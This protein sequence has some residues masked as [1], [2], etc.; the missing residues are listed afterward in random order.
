MLCGHRFQLRPPLR[1]GVALERRRLEQRVDPLQ[2]GPRLRGQSNV[3]V[4]VLPDLGRVDVDVHDARPRREG[5]QLARDTV[6]EA[7][8]HRHEQVGA[9]DR[10][11]GR[12]GAVHPQHLQR[13]RVRLR[14][15]PQA[16]QRL[17]DGHAGAAH[18]LAEL[19]A[20]VQAAPPAVEDG[21][22]RT[23]QGVD[24]G[25]ERLEGGRGGQAGDVAR[26]RHPLAP[27]R[28]AQRLLH[29][30]RD[31]HQHGPGP[32]RP[33]QEEGLLH[34]AREVRDVHHQ[35]VVLGDLPRHLD[36]RRLLEGVGADHPPRD[37]AR[38]GHERHRVEQRVGEAGDEVGGPGARGG[39]ADAD[40]ARRLGVPLGGKDLAL[41]VPAQ[42]VA[43]GVGAGQGLVDLERGAP[44]VAEGDGDPLALE[45][46]D[47]DVCALARRRGA[48][49]VDPV[50][51]R[52]RRRQRRGGRGAVSFCCCRCCFSCLAGHG[53]R[54]VGA[55]R[56][57]LCVCV[58]FFRRV[59][60]FREVRGGK[61]FIIV[62]VVRKKK[63]SH[64]FLRGPQ[65][66]CRGRRGLR[67]RGLL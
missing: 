52:V 10:R 35:V 49:A 28:H 24:D 34:H 60:F 59:S 23:L 22:L 40:V 39:D 8:A 65:P 31:V 21:P 55:S 12:D 15:D 48:E 27:V 1:K 9:V 14:E 5:L 37:L 43:D 45:G 6:V 44:G 33:R 4:L 2:R 56:G 61:L 3:R 17:R 41:L 26:D 25:L 50:C 54:G 18:E 19:R 67:R 29:V 58:L 66:F 32:T 64:L 63:K 16:H 47:E 62:V 46:L 36:D 57:E 42:D 53:G 7:H 51:G 11:V 38:D 20:R 13:E 30:L